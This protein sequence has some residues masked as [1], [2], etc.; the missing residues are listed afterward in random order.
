LIDALLDAAGLGGRAWRAEPIAGDGLL[1]RHHLVHLATG[2]RYVVRE[3][4]WPFDEPPRFDRMA[5]EVWLLPLLTA[6]AVPVPRLLATYRDDA[7]S[8]ILLDY[9]DGSTLG[10]LDGASPRFWF[11]AGASLRVVH[12]TRLPIGP[13]PPGTLT[14]DGVDPFAGGWADWHVENTR[15]HA[16]MLAASRPELGIDPERC[17]AVVRA[18]HPRIGA[19]PIGL[20]HCDANPWNVMIERESG[21]A[22]WIDWEFAALGDPLYD[23]VRMR[24]ARKR[25][26]GPLPA[27]FFDG[28]G[29]DPTT[30]VVFDVYTLGFQLWMGNEAVWGQLPLPVTYAAAERYLRSLPEELARLERALS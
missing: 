14:A 1:N 20:L 16:T 9:I 21:A 3:Y 17:A 22:V 4:G 30:D 27:A 12:E 26:L 10:T 24:W 8:A 5:K 28:Y 29:G 13:L 23:F 7:C 15:H 6:A 18:A 2:E 19:R 25:D 11:A